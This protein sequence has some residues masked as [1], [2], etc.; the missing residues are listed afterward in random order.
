MSKSSVPAVG[1]WYILPNLLRPE[2]RS[3]DRRVLV[4]SVDRKRVH[5]ET[6]PRAG[7]SGG[8]VYPISLRFFRENAREICNG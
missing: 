5:Y 8:Y 4:R 1:S 7:W 2:D 6:E 3:F